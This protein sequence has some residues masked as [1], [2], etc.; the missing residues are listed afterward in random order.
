MAYD[1][2]LIIHVRSFILLL[3]SPDIH[4]LEVAHY[5]HLPFTFILGYPAV[6]TSAEALHVQILVVLLRLAVDH[7]LG[8]LG[9]LIKNF[10]QF[11]P[12]LLELLVVCLVHDLGA[13]YLLPV[14]FLRI[15]HYLLLGY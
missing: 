1:G 15:H 14:L 12:L 4:F 13:E 6:K 2:D 5:H 10:Y 9:S 8:E 11:P 7:H 3:D